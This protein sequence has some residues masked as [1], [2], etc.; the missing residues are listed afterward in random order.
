[1]DQVIH[2]V[3]SGSERIRQLQTVGATL[4]LPG[5][6]SLR[7]NIAMERPRRFRLQAG[8]G[9]A[10]EEIDLGSNDELF[11]L[12]VRRNQPTAIYYCRHD[13]F[14]QSVARQI[15]P[16]EPQWLMEAL[17][18]IHFDPAVRHDG[19]LPHPSGGMEIRSTI[20]SAEGNLTKVTVVDAAYG[21]VLQQHVYDHQGQLLASA[22]AS[23]H[24]YDGTSG[25]SLPRH[26]EIQLPP[27]QMSFTVDVNDYMINRLG[28][29]PVQLWSMP[30]MEGYPLVDLADPRL[31]M[32]QAV[33]MSTAPLPVPNR[34]MRLPP[35]DV[36]RLPPP[37]GVYPRR[38]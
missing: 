23:R 25:V 5:A 37:Y 32:P 8:T 34:I 3:N 30:R 35:P 9:I 17:G 16:V 13:Q 24:R 14:R 11:W 19:P 4:S 26:V 10:G 2:H 15:I 21:W 29:N 1:L 28:G 6:P 12:W 18:V 38:R 20:P 7:A 36:G 31:R 22:L 33:P 27:A